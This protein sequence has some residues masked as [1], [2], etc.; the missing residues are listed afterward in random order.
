[1]AKFD[2]GRRFG[3]DA[4]R[5]PADIRLVLLPRFRDFSMYWQVRALRAPT[6]PK[7]ENTGGSL[8]LVT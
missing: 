4:R 2:Y 8:E 6:R 3:F 1:M 7:L 5:R